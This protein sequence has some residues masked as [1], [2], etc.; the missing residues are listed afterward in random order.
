MAELPQRRSVRR[1]DWDYASPGAYFITITTRG[2]L[3]RF[4]ANDRGRLIHSAARMM[5]SRI[6]LEIPTQFPNV[7][8]DRFV[9]MPNHL[10]GILWIDS[11]PRPLRAGI[12]R[13]IMAFKSRTTV[14]YIRGVWEAGGPPFECRLWH[15]NYYDRII[16]SPAALARTRAY[17]DANPQIHWRR[18][19]LK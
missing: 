8:I 13:I 15:R 5:A 7:R 1:Y 11:T 4:G 2:G 18:A 6:W 16:Y 12:A 17:I 10:H 19:S 14:A 9:V 3:H